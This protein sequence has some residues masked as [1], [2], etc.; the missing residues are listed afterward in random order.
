MYIRISGE[1]NITLVAGVLRRLVSD[2]QRERCSGIL[3]D[4]AD[5]D[6]VP[7][8]E[9]VDIISTSQAWQNILKRYC[10]AI[11]VSKPVQYGIA[12]VLARKSE[13]HGGRVERFYDLESAL[14]WLERIAEDNARKLRAG[15]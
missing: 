10:V 11:V 1:L 3:F 6:Y 5:S 4:A 14:R 9:E 7:S 2:F 8:K 12:N 15:L 13:S